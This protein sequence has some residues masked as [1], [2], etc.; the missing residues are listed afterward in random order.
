MYTYIYRERE[1]AREEER[2]LDSCG[3]A[4]CTTL[5]R[6]MRA[7]HMHTHAHTCTTL[8]RTVIAGDKYM[9]IF[10]PGVLN[11]KAGFFL[12]LF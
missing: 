8:R 5:R 6:T 10:P 12:S 2:D 3:Y 9:P 4:T 11:S 7:Q 1:R